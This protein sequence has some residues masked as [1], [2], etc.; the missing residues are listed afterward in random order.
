MQVAGVFAYRLSELSFWTWIFYIAFS[1]LTSAL[2]PSSIR[3]TSLVWVSFH[4]SWA[5]LFLP[6]HNMKG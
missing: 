4:Q 2:D 3:R 5:S 1:D 6:S